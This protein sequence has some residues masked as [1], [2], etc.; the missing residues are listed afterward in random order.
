M[1]SKNAFLS[2]PQKPCGAAP[3]GLQ[4]FAVI[5][6]NPA[7]ADECPLYGTHQ[8]NGDF[9]FEAAHPHKE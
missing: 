8:Y 9:Q 3:A 5:P 6:L 7:F 1:M 2:R 4:L